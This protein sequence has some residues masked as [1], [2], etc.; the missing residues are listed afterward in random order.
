MRVN[1]RSAHAKEP[2]GK[3]LS[4]T[5][6]LRA[7]P[8]SHPSKFVP[9]LRRVSHEREVPLRGWPRQLYAIVF[10]LAYAIAHQQP[11]RRKFLESARTKL[12]RRAA[13]DDS[14][15]LVFDARDALYTLHAAY[16]FTDQSLIAVR[17][18]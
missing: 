1:S 4:T 3:N 8:T 18:R 12:H 6:C 7:T 13:L 16:G 2:R 9:A 15:N 10:A 17:A 11:P 5:I 14:C